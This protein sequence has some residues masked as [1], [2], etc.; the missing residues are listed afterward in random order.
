MQDTHHRFYVMLTARFWGATTGMLCALLLQNCQSQLNVLEEESP[1][2]A[3]SQ[4]GCQPPASEV[5]TQ[6]L[7]YPPSLPPARTTHQPKVPPTAPSLPL[8]PGAS[9]PT[10]FAGALPSTGIRPTASTARSRNIF[11]QDSS[12]VFMTASG[13]PVT[14]SQVDGLWCAAMQEDSGVSTLQRTLPVVDSADIGSFLSWPQSQ[15]SS[16]SRAH[17]HVLNAAQSSHSSCVYLGRA[18]L[19]GGMPELPSQ[20]VS[21]APRTTAQASFP[22]MAFGAKEWKQYFGDVGL[23]PDLPSDIA[24]ILD[25]PCPFWPDKHVKDTHLLMLVPATVDGKPLTLNLLAELIQRPEGGGSKTEYRYYGSDVERE[26]GNQPSRGAYWVLMTRDVLPNSRNKT[27]ENQKKLLAKHVHSKGLA[28]YEVPHALEAVV[29][30]LLHY[31]RT[32]ERLYADAPW[33]YT[34]CQEAVDNN[35]YPIVVGG[36][37]SGGLIVYC[38]FYVHEDRGVSCLRKF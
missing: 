25:G 18:G 16:T 12:P 34:C 17:I 11:A 27:Y 5:L 8:L 38:D 30:I 7:G 20:G 31:V 10:A 9:L 35:S 14:L 19:W 32:G 21:Q 6:P 28:P 24:A 29:A 37:S 3:P 36:F 33:T 4:A 15:D 2:E 1:A 22:N 13:E 26:L 23:V